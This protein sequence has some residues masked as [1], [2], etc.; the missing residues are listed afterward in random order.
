MA[1]YGYYSPRTYGGCEMS[2]TIYN[3]NYN[4][5]HNMDTM[6]QEIGILETVLGMGSL[7]TVRVTVY[8]K[9]VNTM[10]KMVR[11]SIQAIRKNKRRN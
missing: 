9:R 1:S 8:T 11:M 4:K 5:N 6:M 10:R 2:H 3:K 7:S